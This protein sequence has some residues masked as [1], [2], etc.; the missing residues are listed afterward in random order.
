LPG[1]RVKV[2]LADD[3]PLIIAG[4][5]RAL[6]DNED[7][8]IVGEAQSG[9][10]VMPL[11]ERRRPH[12]VLMDL[13]MPGLPVL[14][15]IERIAQN[16]PEIKTVVLSACD[17]QPSIDAALNAGA[18]A[19]VV[20]S[21]KPIDIGSLLRQACMGAVFHPGS[22]SRRA[23]PHAPAP[24]E[25]PLLTEREQTI[26]DAVAS[27]LTTAAIS[28]RLWVSQHTVKFHLTNIYRKLGVENR[29]SAIRYALEHGLAA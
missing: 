2:L 27:G 29:A 8:E 17:D 13:R 24:T 10:E 20:K 23:D 5:R 1:D 15:C 21:V 3:H 28:Q 18:A 25:G 12:V 14:E 11:V 22:A 19:Y 26:L 6:E 4:I 9:S 16:W 7:I